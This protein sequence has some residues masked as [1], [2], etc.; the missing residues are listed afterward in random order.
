[1]WPFSKR[2]EAPVEQPKPAT[3]ISPAK[4]KYTWPD[5]EPIDK[6]DPFW[7]SNNNMNCNGVQYMKREVSPG[8]WQWVENEEANRHSAERE[9]RRRF[10]FAALWTRVLAPEEE[11]EA[12]AMGNSLNIA[13]MTPYYAADKQRELNDAWFQQRR[14]QAL[15]VESPR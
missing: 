10:I 12:L 6:S 14:L 13:P 11:A 9:A 5:C 2:A 3:T 7:K 1:M 15:L 4:P 8:R